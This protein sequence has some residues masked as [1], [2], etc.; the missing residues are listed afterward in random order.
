MLKRVETAA[1]LRTS[2]RICAL[3]VALGMGLVSG[4][5]VAQSE[6]KVEMQPST[7]ALDAEIEAPMQGFD[8]PNDNQVN[9]DLLVLLDEQLKKITKLEADLKLESCWAMMSQFS[10][11]Q[12]SE[13]YE[14]SFTGTES[15]QS[16][17]NDCQMNVFIQSDGIG[18]K[19]TRRR[20]TGPLEYEQ[21]DFHTGMNLDVIPGDKFFFRSD[22]TSQSVLRSSLVLALTNP[23][24]SLSIPVVINAEPGSV[25]SSILTSVIF[26][27]WGAFDFLVDPIIILSCLII[28]T[29]FVVYFIARRIWH[30]TRGKLAYESSADGEGDETVWLHIGD[31]SIPVPEDYAGEIKGAIKVLE[32]QLEKEALDSP[33]VR[34][35]L[36]EEKRHAD[37][38]AKQ[39][40]I[41]KY[42]Q[43]DLEERARVAESRAAESRVGTERLEIDLAKLSK[44]HEEMHGRLSDMEV[45]RRVFERDAEHARAELNGAM[46][47]LADVR[48]KL[49]GEKTENQ[50]LREESEEIRRRSD[51]ALAEAQATWDEFLNGLPMFLRQDQKY[52]DN[53]KEMR[54]QAPTE[55]K[56]FELALRVFHG[57]GEDASHE[58]ITP[59]LVDI[60]DKLFSTLDALKYSEAN[61]AVEA[62]L[63]ARALNSEIPGLKL[64]VPRTDEEYDNTT[65][66][67][68]GGGRTVVSVR[69]WGLKDNQEYTVRKAK[70]RT[71]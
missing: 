14:V 17:G 61:K 6:S 40:Q 7:P 50:N 49:E 53:F 47:A 45:D 31:K 29:A 22:G 4:S 60:G 32:R 39:V 69:S 70:V 8:L 56:R 35:A 3:I 23:T 67:G 2:R 51:D 66:V 63:W 34:R 38:R 36:A 44:A 9:S 12:N 30:F 16:G 68:E 24:R 48:R 37:E 58:E 54:R 43:T 28:I 5:A 55:L 20:Y 65:M 64:F 33:A 1:S 19:G 26:L 59:I 13:V 52:T 62:V 42:E 15:L 18:I 11:E 10:V 27:D 71:G 21:I 57:A 25:N 46:D 41:L